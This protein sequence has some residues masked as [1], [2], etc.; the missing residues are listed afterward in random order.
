MHYDLKQIAPE[1]VQGEQLKTRKQLTSGFENFPAL[2]A[3]AMPK[4]HSRQYRYEEDCSS[5]AS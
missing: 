3:D 5:V 4:K 1:R 2:C